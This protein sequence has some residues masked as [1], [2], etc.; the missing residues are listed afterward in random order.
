MVPLGEQKQMEVA[1]AYKTSCRY[2]TYSRFDT[3]KSDK[4]VH[5]IHKVV[6][7][8]YLN[9]F[10]AN[11]DVTRL[12]NLSS[13][14]LVESEHAKSIIGVKMRGEDLYGTFVDKRI[15]SSMQKIH[16]PIKREKI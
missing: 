1:Q 13:G 11:I 5:K 12:Y 7:Q 8:E 16:D 10:D 4:F 3:I 15:K 14:V 6:T 2:V 9:P